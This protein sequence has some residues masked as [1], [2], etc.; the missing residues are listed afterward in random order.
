MAE[1][2]VKNLEAIEQFVDAI[3]DMRQVTRKQA[4]DIR[5]QLS[6][7]SNWLEKAL[8]DYWR[9]EYR[10]AENRW[11]EAREELLRCQAK[12][13]AEDETSCSV[14]RKMLDRAT[15]RRAVCEQRVR[16]VPH[17]AREWSQFL[18]DLS[19]TVRQFDDLSES[20]LQL[21]LSR[22]QSILESLRKYTQSQP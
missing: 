11:I 12:T 18:Q 4:D 2:N 22:L 16:T 9:N 21:A 6:R 8:P 14:Q 3:A 20:T 17:C 1:A 5:E 7:I 19:T 13:R 10:V 15:Q